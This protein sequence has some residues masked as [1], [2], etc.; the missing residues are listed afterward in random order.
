M[1]LI[2]KFQ[3]FKWKRNQWQTLQPSSILHK[4]TCD[5]E[6]QVLIMVQI[7]GRDKWIMVQIKGR[8]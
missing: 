2:R 3:W 6:D 8:D 4:K 1:M 5:T 7:K